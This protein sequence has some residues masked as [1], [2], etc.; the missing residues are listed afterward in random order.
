MSQFKVTPAELE[1]FKTAVDAQSNNFSLSAQRITF[2]RDGRTCSLVVNGVKVLRGAWY[3]V[4]PGSAEF[5]IVNANEYDHAFDFRN[6]HITGKGSRDLAWRRALEAEL[7]T[8]LGIRSLSFAT[9]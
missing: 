6:L 2:K 7:A 4:H 5:F 9:L 1:T 3:F 8:L